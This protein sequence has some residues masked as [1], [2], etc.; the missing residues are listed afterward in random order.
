MS[1]RL[2]IHKERTS[3]VINGGKIHKIDRKKKDVKYGTR[4][5]DKIRDCDRNKSGCIET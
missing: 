2:N 5:P 4:N 3:Y 1:R